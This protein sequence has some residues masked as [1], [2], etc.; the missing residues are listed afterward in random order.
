MLTSN[1]YPWLW[2]EK[3]T[4]QKKRGR[5]LKIEIRKEFE[6]FFLFAV[7]LGSLS[8][9]LG[10]SCGS[11]K[12][13]GKHNNHIDTYGSILT[14]AEDASNRYLKQRWCAQMK[15]TH[16]DHNSPI[17]FNVMCNFIFFNAECKELGGLR[18]FCRSFVGHLRLFSI[19]YACI[20]HLV[21]R[22][23]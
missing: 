21:V 11:P 16:N 6:G 1:S 3:R 17:T 22:A 12:F 15:S 19:I 20:R 13:L 18:I 8:K 14:N 4:R 23:P 9:Y 10:V 2:H 7:A 5:K